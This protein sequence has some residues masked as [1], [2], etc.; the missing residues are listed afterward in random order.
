MSLAFF[1]TCGILIRTKQLLQMKRSTCD[2]LLATTAFSWNTLKWMKETQVNFF[3]ALLYLILFYSFI[4][5]IYHSILLWALVYGNICYIRR[6]YSKKKIK[7]N[8]YLLSSPL[9]SYSIPSLSLPLSL[10]F[11]SFSSAAPVL[12]ALDCNDLF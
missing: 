6:S 1:I 2:K 12:F 4:Y 7:C 3:T 10:L 5:F 8:S 11:R 9:P